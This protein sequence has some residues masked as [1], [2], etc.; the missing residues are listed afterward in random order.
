[1]LEE[2]IMLEKA[3]MKA[4]FAACSPDKPKCKTTCEKGDHFHCV[5]WAEELANANKYAE[6]KALYVKA[7]D[8]KVMTACP[9]VGQID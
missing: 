4:A 2:A 3:N 8:G 9:L 6:A 5:V 1:M 7:C